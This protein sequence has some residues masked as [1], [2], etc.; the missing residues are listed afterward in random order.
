MFKILATTAALSL[1]ALGAANAATVS[2]SATPAAAF[3]NPVGSVISGTYASNVTDPGVFTGSTDPLPLDNRRSPW[4]GTALDGS[5]YSA[6]TGRVSYAFGSVRT[7]FSLVWGSPDT[8]NDLK[9]FLGGNLV[10]TVN[11][12]AILPCCGT[13]VASSLVTISGLKFDSV[14]FRS[15]AQAFEYANVAAVPVPAAGLMLLG[16]VGGLAVLRRR[17]K[18]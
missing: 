4:E 16:A 13:N 7:A 14:E 11:G 18:A 1:A 15:G 12:S 6:I 17:A 10:D 3:A 5:V 8:Y 2:Q 9:F